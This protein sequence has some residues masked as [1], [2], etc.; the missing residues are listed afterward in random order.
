MMISKIIIQSCA[1]LGRSAGEILTK[2]NEALCSNNR[3]Q[4]FVTV[5][6][7]ILEIST[8]KLT[9]ANAGHEYPVLMKDGRF[10]LFK[11]RHGLVIGGFDGIK[12]KE[13]ELMLQPG[14]KLFVYTDGVAE[15]MN[16]DKEL[17]GTDRL[18]DALNM[19][20]AERPLNVLRNVRK[21]VDEF[22]GD[23]E[24]FDDLTMLCMEYK[25]M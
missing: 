7:G 19:G 17:F 5:W 18:L 11:D 2:T 8:G 16:K 15:A 3:M 6:L 22:V 9:A 12:Y 14:D 21:S 13:Y 20:P 24:Q 23:A 25:G 10:E 4:M 1:M